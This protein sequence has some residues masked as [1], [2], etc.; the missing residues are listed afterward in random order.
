MPCSARS[1][2]ASHVIL[3]SGES[4]PTV[5]LVSI[6]DKISREGLSERRSAVDRDYAETSESVRKA[7][8]PLS[9]S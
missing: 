3:F 8:S 7:A 5:L 2:S 4:C 6:P 1:R 9:A